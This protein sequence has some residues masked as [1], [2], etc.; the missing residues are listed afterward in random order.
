MA[1]PILP[2]LFQNLVYPVA[3]TA[4]NLAGNAYILGRQIKDLRAE[5]KEMRDEL[6]AEI[7]EMR[8]DLGGQVQKMRDDLKELEKDVNALTR[9]QS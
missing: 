6:R 2:S 3:L 7:K 9:R 4:F 8:N 1:A 5:V